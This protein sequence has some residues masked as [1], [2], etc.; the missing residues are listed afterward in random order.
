MYY[1]EQNQYLNIKKHAVHNITWGPY[2][3][4]VP[5][6]CPV[7]PCAKTALDRV[8]LTCKNFTCYTTVHSQDKTHAYGYS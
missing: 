8:S 7:C 2:A 3:R 4:G 6:N 1:F 5:G